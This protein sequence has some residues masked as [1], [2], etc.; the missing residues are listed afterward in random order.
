MT[1]L[2]G[3][4]A[5]SDSGKILPIPK[6]AYLDLLSARSPSEFQKHYEGTFNP[7]APRNSGPGAFKA[8]RVTLLKNGGVNL[9]CPYCGMCQVAL[10]SSRG[11]ADKCAGCHMFFLVPENPPEA[12]DLLRVYCPHCGISP[13]PPLKAADLGKI[14]ACHDC[15]KTY[16]VPASAQDLRSATSQQASG[17]GHGQM[18]HAADGTLFGR[19]RVVVRLISDGHP[20]AQVNRHNTYVSTGEGTIGAIWE[21]ALE[22]GGPSAR[23]FCY[24]C[25]M[26]VDQPARNEPW[27]GKG[28]DISKTEAVG[29]R[30]LLWV[31]VDREGRPLAPPPARS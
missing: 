27:D 31:A 30:T 21:V 26:Y 22:P 2:R 11:R 4:K 16:T 7:V 10:G 28:M 15:Q 25:L 5:L 24:A 14:V 18:V 6:D 8:E 9:R 23:M 20:H 12:D 13:R 29:S 1:R 19:V 3:R 17:P